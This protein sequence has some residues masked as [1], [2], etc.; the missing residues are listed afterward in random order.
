MTEQE[1]PKRPVGRPP[2]FVMPPRIDDDPERIAEIFL[3]NP[4]PKEWQ[5]L[6]NHREPTH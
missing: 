5:Y 4:P 2:K 3:R 1:K 6:K